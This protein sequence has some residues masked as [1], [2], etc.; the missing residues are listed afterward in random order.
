MG[1]AY[2][3]AVAVASGSFP[4]ATVVPVFAGLTDQL[5]DRLARQGFVIGMEVASGRDPPAGVVQ[6]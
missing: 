1:S 4:T 3:V 6:V 5:D 2:V